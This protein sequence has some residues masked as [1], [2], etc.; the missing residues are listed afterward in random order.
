MSL[1][2]V[3]V[4]MIDDDPKDWRIY[5]NDHEVTDQVRGI[6]ITGLAGKA[7]TCMIKIAGTIAIPDVALATLQRRGELKGEGVTN[8][9]R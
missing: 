3:R 5:L 7:T 1:A 6:K 4:E 9:D 2:K 8:G